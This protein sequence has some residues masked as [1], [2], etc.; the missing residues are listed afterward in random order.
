MFLL[1][2]RAGAGERMLICEMLSTREMLS[3]CEVVF[4]FEVMSDC[5]EKLV[6][7]IIL[8]CEV[9]PAAMCLF[10]LTRRQKL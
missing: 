4:V 8:A 7:A 2:G 6:C 9:M 3:A 10:E 1:L 5:D